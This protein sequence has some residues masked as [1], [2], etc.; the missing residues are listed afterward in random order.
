MS[1]E[2]S[3]E[4]IY[5]EV[6][7]ISERID[8]LEDLIEEIIISDLPRRRLSDEEVREIKKAIEEMRKGE[9]VDLEELR[10]A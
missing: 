1:G 6:K 4:L 10:S 7:K 9:Y 8:F 2:V 3:L 5:R